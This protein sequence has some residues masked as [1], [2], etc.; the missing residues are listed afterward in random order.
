[1]TMISDKERASGRIK[2][3]ATEAI[4]TGG[5]APSKRLADSWER[6][7]ISGFQSATRIL[8]PLLGG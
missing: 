1:M 7:H 4:A 3:S 5:S 6:L 2:S 8:N